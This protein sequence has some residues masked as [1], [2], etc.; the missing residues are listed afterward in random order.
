MRVEQVLKVSSEEF[1]SFIKK[2]L[3]S[4]LKQNNVIDEN[5][6]NY[7][8]KKGLQYEKI[9]KSYNPKRNKKM[10]VTI[11]NFEENKAYKVKFES[12]DVIYFISFDIEEVEKGIN[13]SYSEEFEVIKKRPLISR[14]LFPRS[15]KKN[16]KLHLINNLKVIESEII[17]LRN[18]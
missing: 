9:L 1:F 16:K 13:V 17:N 6:E 12:D 2:G 15:Q 10:V 3:I 5:I 7:E 8:I 18:K 11:E 4:D 14:I